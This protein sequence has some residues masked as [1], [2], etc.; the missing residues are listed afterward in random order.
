MVREMRK[1]ECS[2]GEAAE[3]WL[4]CERRVMADGRWLMADGRMQPMQGV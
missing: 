3:V 1:E 2:G 4:R